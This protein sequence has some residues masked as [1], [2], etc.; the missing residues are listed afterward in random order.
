MQNYLT[1]EHHTKSIHVVFLYK[2]TVQ[3][4]FEHAKHSLVKVSNAHQL[5]SR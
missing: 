1:T 3:H 4:L 5:M 2:G